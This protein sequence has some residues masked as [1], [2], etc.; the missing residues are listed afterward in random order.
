MRPLPPF[1]R[2]VSLI[3]ALACLSLAACD[4]VAEPP[5]APAA[6]APEPPAPPPAPLQP[7]VDRA[8]LLRALD[9]AASAFAAGQPDNGAALN[10]RRY[11][12]RQAFGCAGPAPAGAARPAGLATWTWGPRN[13]T[14]EIALQ[15]A[16][17]TGDLGTSDGDG[18]APEA[19]EGFWLARPWMRTDGCPA[20]A[21]DLPASPPEAPMPTKAGTTRPPPVSPPQRQTAGQA[22]VFAQGGSRVGRRD[23]RAFTHTIRGEDGLPPAPVAGYRLVIEGRFTAFP[24]GQTV[25]CRAGAQDERPVC[26]AASTIDRVVFETADGQQLSEWRPG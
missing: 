13:Q 5:P 20:A 7:V 15:P 19:I 8:E 16:D 24:G 18:D 12:V 9:A 4:R 22:S 25:H 17:W 3:G 14:I 23:G 2:R 11:S 21:V 26:I 10:G 6:P 1:A